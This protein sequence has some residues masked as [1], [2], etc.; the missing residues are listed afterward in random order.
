MGVSVGMYQPRRRPS[1]SQLETVGIVKAARGGD[2]VKKGECEGA[3]GAP[4]GRAPA[5]TAPP[6]A[7]SGGGELASTVGAA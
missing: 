5:L 1:G 6:A 7:S 4:A 3:S 2:G